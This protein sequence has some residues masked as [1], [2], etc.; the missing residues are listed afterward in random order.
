[1]KALVTGGTRGIGKSIS[2]VLLREGYEVMITGTS[3]DLSDNNA[4][5][6]F[7]VD[8]KNKHSTEK[9]LQEAKSFQPEILINNAGINIIDNFTDIKEQDFDNVMRVNLKIPFLIS[10]LVIPGMKENN[11]G[12]IVNI[13]S[14]F[15]SVSKERRA[16][17]S[18]SKFGLVGLTKALSAELSEFNILANCVSPGVIETRLTK[19]ILGIKGISE[20][21][22]KIPQGRLGSVEEVA[23][24]VFWLA[25]KNNS[26]ITGQNILIDG[27]YTVV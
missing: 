27:G 15:S 14:I 25:S 22:K 23:E 6:C 13:G 17:Y 12:R 19:E 11:F 9:F 10:Q 18:V 4:F 5:R 20:M 2:Q 8:F 16:S 1:M 26:Y 7:E 3:I 21:K 24:L